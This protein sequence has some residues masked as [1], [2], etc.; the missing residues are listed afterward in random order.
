LPTIITDG[1]T[2]VLPSGWD[3]RLPVAYNAADNTARPDKA[4]VAA[5]K[6]AELEPQIMDA[7]RKARD[8]AGLDCEADCI[9]KRDVLQAEYD[10]I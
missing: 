6:R 10:A 9:A 7:R 1:S 2:F 3:G 5:A 8:A 4:A